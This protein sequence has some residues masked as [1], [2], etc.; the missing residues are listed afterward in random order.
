MKIKDFFSKLGS[1]IKDLFNNIRHADYTKPFKK[2][3]WID[4]FLWLKNKI[5][6]CGAFII[7]NKFLVCFLVMLLIWNIFLQIK[8][9]NN[10][11]IINNLPSSYDLYDIKLDLR[12]D[13]EDISDELDEIN[14]Q[15]YDLHDR[16]QDL[17]YDSHTHYY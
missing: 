5:L 13:I 12:R 17:E 1:R 3:T 11:N 7:N 6:A 4:M 15:L 10:A 9:N 8:V 14:N 2:Q 16:I